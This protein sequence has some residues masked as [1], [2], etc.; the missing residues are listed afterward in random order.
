MLR[1]VLQRVLTEY[2][3][4]ITEY[5]AGNPTVAFIQNVAPGILANVLPAEMATWICQGSA[6][7]GKFSFVPWFVV[8]DPLVTTSVTEGYYVGYLFNQTNN[9]VY[10]T[11]NQGTTNLRNE[12]HS[13]VRD[14][15][16]DRATIMRHRVQ[17]LAIQF[18]L[19]P[20]VLG[21]DGMRPRD[22]Q[23]GHVFGRQY[24]LD[25]LPNEDQL[26]ADLHQILW[27]YHA[28]TFR[29]G[30]SSDVDDASETSVLPG[31][32]SLTIREKRQYKLH[33]RIERNAK[34]GRLAKQ[35]HGT[36]CQVCCF[37]FA[38]FYGEIGK[39]F[40]EAHHLKP[41]AMLAENVVVEY[42]VATDF[43][44]LCPNCHR[45]IHHMED[46]SNINGLKSLLKSTF[47]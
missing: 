44:V 7:Q 46:V 25:T 2:S 11:L 27:A 23:A 47:C 41:L 45:M 16:R 28:L 42:N 8:M 15:L 20:I 17:D 19:T 9:S 5:F 37:N 39:D 35:L 29:G 3:H 43:A 30:V 12:F 40:I 33:K 14:V 31:S 32:A 26:V 6:G 36:T 10:L 13:N 34:G 38:A 18:D 22:Y 21:T 1:L 4:A 24:F